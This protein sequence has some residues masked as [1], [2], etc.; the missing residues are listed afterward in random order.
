MKSATS[1]GCLLCHGKSSR[2][3]FSY[4]RPDKYEAAVG[5]G[6]KD[7][8]RKWVE[9]K[10]CGLHYSVYSRPEKILDKI[11][12][13]AYRNKDSSWRGDSP[14]DICKKVAAL[15]RGG[16]ETKFR[17]AWIKKNIA[18]LWKDGLARKGMPP[19]KALDIGGGS[20]VFAYEFRD[21]EW[22]TYIID[23]AKNTA[24]IKTELRIPLIQRFYAPRSFKTKF[25]LISLIYV[26]EHVLNPILF[27]KNVRKDMGNNSF[28]YLE[29]PDAVSF[30]LKPPD[31]DI[32]N[33]CHLWMFNTRTLT[34]LLDLCGFEVL[35]LVR[36]KVIRGHFGLIA[37]AGLK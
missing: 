31:D 33:S 5:V 29:V 6:P 17:V 16:S 2:I 7:Y 4:T 35:R 30:R 22:Q 34:T 21:I 23:P 8:S 26:L 11:Y 1:K 9:C 14:E 36:L 27:L 28:L 13:S 3:V 37:L 32:F 10:T 15:P 19:Y 20:G 12:L 24:F 25:T 18:E